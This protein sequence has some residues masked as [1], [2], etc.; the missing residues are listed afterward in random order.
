MDN[1]LT[2]NTEEKIIDAAKKV[3]MQKGMYGARMQEIADEAG[4]NKAL[5]HY[6]FRNKKKLFEGIFQELFRKF[7]P[8]AIGILDSEE[9]L[10]SKIRRLVNSYITM[11]SED[12]FL[13]VFVISEI[14]QNP[15]IISSVKKLLSKVRLSRF[16]QQLQEGIDQGLYKPVPPAQFM[17]NMLSMC[18][19]P[20]LAKPIISEAFSLDEKAFS[21]FIEERKAL[22]PDLIL[23]TII[24]KPK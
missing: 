1:T 14:H 2:Q 9:P 21:A 10:E 18:I 13:P 6:Y 11:L 17:V 7:L 16:V 5:L 22:L 3:F 15:E 20:F 12:P 4:I 19:F 23:N 8:S 24:K